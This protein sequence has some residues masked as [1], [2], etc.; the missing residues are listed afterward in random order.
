MATMVKRIER[1]RVFSVAMFYL[2]RLQSDYMATRIRTKCSQ[3]V[4]VADG[5]F[6]LY[7]NLFKK[8]FV[9]NSSK[10]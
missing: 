7:Y 1:I 5:Y 2:Y 6:E 4:I 8:S 3:V 10:N 9:E